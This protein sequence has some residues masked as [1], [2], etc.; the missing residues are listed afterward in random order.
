V[1][2]EPESEAVRNQV[3]QSVAD[4]TAKFPLYPKRLKQTV[5]EVAGS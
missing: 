1:V 3:K 5:M 2:R 4:L